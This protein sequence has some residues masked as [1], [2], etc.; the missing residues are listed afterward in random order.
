MKDKKMFS[1]STVFALIVTA[2]AWSE[3]FNLFGGKPPKSQ[4][5][6]L[7]FAIMATAILII[8]YFANKYAR[9]TGIFSAI[10]LVSLLSSCDVGVKKDQRDKQRLLYNTNREYRYLYDNQEVAWNEVYSVESKISD[11]M[12][13]SIIGVLDPNFDKAKTILQQ[14]RRSAQRM[15]D[16]MNEIEKNSR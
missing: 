7:A 6:S 3:Y 1:I 8:L 2:F 16:R 13:D 14:K 10:I 12:A 4:S 9:K 15:Q 11:M 5:L